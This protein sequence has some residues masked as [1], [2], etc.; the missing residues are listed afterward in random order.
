MQ[1]AERRAEALRMRESGMGVDEIREAMGYR[2]NRLV[3]QD[4]RKAREQAFAVRDPLEDELPVD[5]LTSRDRRVHRLIA[6]RARMRERRLQDL[7]RASGLH[8]SQMTAAQLGSR[9]WSLEQY[10]G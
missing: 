6:Q 5:V 3:R 7:L 2:T 4:I 1:V 10:D 8:V 9:V